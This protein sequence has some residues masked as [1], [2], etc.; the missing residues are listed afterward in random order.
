MRLN[1]RIY[2]RWDIDLIALMD[3]G[4]PVIQMMQNALI[5]FAKGQPCFY[6][7]D[8]F[9]QFEVSDKNSLS[10]KINIPNDEKE[11]IYMLSHLKR[12]LK[13]NFCKLVLR[14]ALVSQNLSCYFEDN[15][16]CQLVNLNNYSKNIHSL[17]NVIKC[18]DI[19]RE[20]Y[21]FNAFG[22][23]ITKEFSHQVIGNISANA[24]SNM[25]NEYIVPKK[26]A[27]QN[28]KPVM[29]NAVV[30]EPVVK[31]TSILSA[32]A[33]FNQPPVQNPVQTQPKPVK[34]ENSKN[35]DLISLFDSL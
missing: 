13:N 7:I 11:T 15:N 22:K 6:Y 33:S 18:S 1:V 27:E 2:K 4:Y 8:E 5:C 28:P 35:E 9:T 24:Y 30:F 10:I 19:K 3:A 32:E 14:N 29:E 23:T 25:T 34:E 17:S 12:Y 26:K 20:N 16:L 21:S 31:E